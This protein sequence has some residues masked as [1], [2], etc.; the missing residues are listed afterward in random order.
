[1]YSGGRLSAGFY[2]RF[3]TKKYL[4]NHLKY[5]DLA[6]GY[7]IQFVGAKKFY[8]WFFIISMQFISKI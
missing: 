5:Q 2:R 6:Y 7:L 8:N 3:F 1:M 4:R